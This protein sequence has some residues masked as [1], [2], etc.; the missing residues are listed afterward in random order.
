MAVQVPPPIFVAILSADF[1]RFLN[2]AWRVF[3]QT[4]FRAT[5]WWRSVERNREVGG[6]LYS[7][8]LV[9]LALDVVPLPGATFREVRAE[10]IAAGLYAVVEPDHVHLQAWP[11][12]RLESILRGEAV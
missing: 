4:P 5:S 8:H 11:A 10:A 2:A 1:D 9:G 7:Q 3:N 12:G 6:A